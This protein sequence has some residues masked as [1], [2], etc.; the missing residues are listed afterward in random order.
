LLHL[1]A[2]ELLEH[3]TIDGNDIKIMMNGEKIN[4]S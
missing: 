2:N 3:E 1:M 4:I